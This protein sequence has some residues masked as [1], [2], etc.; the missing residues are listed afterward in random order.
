M[1]SSLVSGDAP[2]I[3][4]LAAP[5]SAPLDAAITRIHI[6][7]SLFAA[8]EAIIRADIRLSGTEQA[9]CTVR[10]RAAGQ[11]HEQ[12]VVLRG[13]HTQTVTFPLII[14]NAGIQDIH[15]D[16]EPLDREASLEN[17]TAT[18]RIK[19][20]ADR[21]RIIALAGTPT[22]DF[23]YLRNLLERSE[24]VTLTD[25]ILAGGAPAA[26]SPE[27]ILNADV[28]ILADVSAASLNVA[29]RDA[30]HRLVTERAAV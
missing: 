20:L 4:V 30:I 8:Q 10:L 17:N 2:V 11:T 19:V 3:A 27:D 18:R 12:Q 22:W 23:Q 24:W 21:T 9:T 28:V 13:E 6:P 15:I 25:A 5:P 16:I 29:Q 7:D 14:D 26:V 1:E